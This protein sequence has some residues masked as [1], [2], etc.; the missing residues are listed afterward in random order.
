MLKRKR[1][2]QSFKGR[3]FN[4]IRRRNRHRKRKTGFFRFYFSVIATAKKD[5][6][7][8]KREDLPQ[9]Q[10]Y[11]GYRPSETAPCFPGFGENINYIAEHSEVQRGDSPY[12]PK[13]G[14]FLVPKQFSLSAKPEESLYFLRG[15]FWALKKDKLDEIFIDYRECELIDLDASICM[16]VI[17]GEFIQF[18]NECRRRR[19]PRRISSIEPIN[20]NKE[21]IR[22]VLFS[23]GAF[24]NIRGLEIKYDN[25]IPFH[26]IIGDNRSSNVRAAK[27]IEVT[28]LVDYIEARLAEMQHTLSWQAANRLSKVI[29]EV[30]IN[31]AEHSG[32]KYRYAIG[33]FEKQQQDT[34]HVGIFNLTIFSFGRTIY[35]NF[36]AIDPDWHVIRRMKELSDKYTSKNLFQARKFEEETLWTLYAL[37]QGVTSLQDRKRGNGSIAFIESF[38]SL[39]GNME[40]DNMS[41]LTIISGHTRIMFDGKYQIKEV[42]RGT[43]GTIFKMMTF[44]DSGNIEDMPDEKYVT[45]ADHFF[46]GTLITAKICIN[47]NN[48]ENE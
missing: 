45:F 13:D 22:K 6:R 28:Q 29:G 40:H 44:N 43:A 47:Y 33:Y 16:D 46:P 18:L 41:S 5:G 1:Y 17:V 23:I 42:P 25:L 26:L 36:K 19:L 27:E 21:Q 3:Y 11:E 2:K 30:L 14:I 39:K 12:I 35:E 37:Q 4:F 31:A 34:G 32:I 48:L 24:R 8:L 20:W 38:F 7:R 15:L 9:F 10:V